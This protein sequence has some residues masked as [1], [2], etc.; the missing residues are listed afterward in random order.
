M[1]AFL[2]PSALLHVAGMLICIAPLNIINAAPVGVVET[3]DVR[4]KYYKDSPIPQGVVL[5][6]NGS[7][8][9]STDGQD[10][11]KLKVGQILE[12]GAH[13]KTGKD[14]RVDL[15]L[16]RLAISIR[17]TS[18]SEVRLEK[19]AKYKKDE[20]LYVQ[21]ILDLKA[22]Q[23]F[24]FVRG[25]VPNSKFEV[26]HA[27]VRSVLEGEGD[28]GYAVRADS[29]AVAPRKTFTPLK[30][31]SE[32]GTSVVAPGQRFDIKQKKTMELAAT[33]V[34]ETMVHLD[35]L[36]ALADLLSPAEEFAKI[37]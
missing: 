31:V 32:T 2:R 11:K 27:G 21:T 15:F 34:E 28:G 5:S 8:L 3:G 7:C 24:C 22:G 12:E 1:K 37:Q 20:V 23:L 10:F 26:K 36:Q 4:I 6:I 9:Y 16:R 35:E 19:M 30:V 13:I 25:V 14:S 17:I 29:A 33:E 18:E